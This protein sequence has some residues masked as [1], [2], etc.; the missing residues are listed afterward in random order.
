MKL[1][2]RI[3]CPDGEIDDF[4]KVIEEWLMEMR[5]NPQSN[6]YG[7]YPLQNKGDCAQLDF[8]FTDSN[9]IFESNGNEKV[10]KPKK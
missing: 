8:E 3:V 1:N 10:V 2:L 5:H 7:E 4:V 6:F 9:L